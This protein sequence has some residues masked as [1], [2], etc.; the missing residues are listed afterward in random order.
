MFELI[1]LLVVVSVLKLPAYIYSYVT[2]GNPL[3]HVGTAIPAITILPILLNSI[4]VLNDG[5]PIF[6]PALVQAFFFAV[7]FVSL[8]WLVAQ[9]MHPIGWLIACE[10]IAVLAVLFVRI[11]EGGNNKKKRPEYEYTTLG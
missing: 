3:G 7:V 8:S 9:R 2:N 4:S 6:P 5:V 11:I 10:V 1:F